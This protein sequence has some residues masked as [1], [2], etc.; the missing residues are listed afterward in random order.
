MRPWE[1]LRE[2]LAA[3]R[4]TRMR[5]LLTALGVVIG[6]AA[7]ITM[8]AL[9]S[10]AQA[11]VEQQLEALGTDLLSISSG[12]SYQRGVA[13]AERVNLTT[14]DANALAQDARTLRA[15]VP[16][17]DGRFQVKF[18]N[19]NTNIEV[20]ATAPEFPGVQ[21]ID[22]ALGRFFTASEDQ[23]RERVAVIG[24]DIPEELEVDPEGLVGQQISI[25]GIPF[26]VIGMMERK[27]DSPGG[28]DVDENI[29][30]PFRTGEYRI[31][32]SDR[33]SRITVQVATPGNLDAALLD[34]ERVLRREH[35]LRPDQP[36][37]FR[38]R[39]RSTFLAAQAEAS[40]TMTWLL[41]GI[42]TV[43]LLVGGIGIMNI[44]LVSVT[45]R[46]REIGVRKALGATY[47]QILM[48][49]LVEALTL[50]LLGGVV[51]ILV[52]VGAAFGLS[53]LNGWPTT[54]SLG[55]IA[56]AVFF[57]V[58]IGLFFG[59]WPARRA[60]RLVPVEALRYE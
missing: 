60:A 36:N 12:R 28:E 51:G 37:D 10:G 55:A 9:G 48:Q 44:M 22:M 43:S 17:L 32:G 24:A 42:A 40:A 29:Y 56:L 4:A 41:G 11:A 49:F 25:R 57:S 20:A 8:V 34:I 27:G 45:E 7:V 23:S 47:H 30:I 33:V 58:G 50:C 19:R 53:A 15:V 39:D 26:L 13:S 54:I 46:T 31:F 6:I 35:R 52:G 38:I 5:S 59:V 16:I 3:I 1:V 14:D 18:G 21:R 2:A